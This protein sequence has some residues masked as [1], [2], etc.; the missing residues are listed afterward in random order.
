LRAVFAV[1]LLVFFAV[2]VAALADGLAAVFFAALPADLLTA[3]LA[4]LLLACF[5]ARVEAARFLRG[6]GVAASGGTIMGS[7]TRPSAASGM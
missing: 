2:L 6:A 3:F 5:A 1:F 7:E 4:V